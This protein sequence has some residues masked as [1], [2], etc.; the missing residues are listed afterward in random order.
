MRIP[1]TGNSIGK[2]FSFWPLGI[3]EVG[4]QKGLPDIFGEN[5]T[6]DAGETCL[7]WSRY[8]FLLPSFFVSK[9]KSMSLAEPFE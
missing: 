8:I 9:L 3:T 2:G 5:G 6:P 4:L 7:A 1:Q